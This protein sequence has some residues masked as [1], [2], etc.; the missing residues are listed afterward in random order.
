MTIIRHTILLLPATT[1][2]LFAAPAASQ[3]ASD[4]PIVVTG[5]KDVDEQIDS[6]VEALTK[7]PVAGQLAK[8]E[9]GICPRALGIPDSYR[10][11]VEQRIRLVAKEVG[12]RV[13]KEQCTANVLIM[14]TKDKVP[15]LK[16]LKTKYSYFF[17]DKTPSE[18]RAIIAQPGPTAAWHIEE[19]LNADGA[20]MGTEEGF[21]VNRTTR[22]A[23]RITAAARPTFVA[24]AMVVEASALVGLSVTQLADYAVMRTFARTDPAR[25]GASAPPTILNIMEAPDNIDLPITLTRWDL[26][27]LKGLY[28][29][30]KNL[31]ASAE[32]SRIGSV[33]RGELEKIGKLPAAE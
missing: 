8:F 27:F 20:P 3:P 17:S 24:A 12:L 29:A 30:P 11:A 2:L 18:Y 1:A 26:G 13:A 10:I 4:V 31:R 15:F 9:S 14:V 28:A 7:A 6:F 33:L 25:L 21:V 5:R 23:S 19:I 32:R 22:G 16:T